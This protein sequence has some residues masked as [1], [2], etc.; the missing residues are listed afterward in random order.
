MLKKSKLEILFLYEDDNKIR[1]IDIFFFN[2]QGVVNDFFG[3]TLKLFDF[4]C[5]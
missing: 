4:I 3:F 2:F 5:A 1:Y